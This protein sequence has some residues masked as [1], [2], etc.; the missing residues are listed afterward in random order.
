MATESWANKITEISLFVEDLLRAKAFYQETFN[1]GIIY[2]DEYCAV[3]DYGNTCINLLD[4]S[5]AQELIEPAQV[6]RSGDGARF[7]FTIQVPDVDQ[8]CEELGRRGVQLLNG[9]V[10]C[11]WG[12]RTACFADPDGH[13]W[14]IAQVL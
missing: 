4:Q 8:V 12:R 3:F 6:R 14:E 7:Q 9:P 2:E 11:P 13:V 5:Q 10:T 1:L